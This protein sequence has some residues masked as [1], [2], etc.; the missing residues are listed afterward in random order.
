MQHE[1][2]LKDAGFISWQEKANELAKI[3]CPDENDRKL[4]DVETYDCVARC[5]WGEMMRN[6]E[7]GNYVEVEAY[8]A[9]AERFLLA[10]KLIKTMEEV[11]NLENDA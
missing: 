7:Y 1:K 2:E 4:L 9:L 10:M 11:Q 8:R 5:E 6:G 3:F